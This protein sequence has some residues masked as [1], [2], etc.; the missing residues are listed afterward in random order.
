[1]KLGRILVVDD[2]T[3]IA[4]ITAVILDLAGKYEIALKT[5]LTHFVDG[6]FHHSLRIRRG[7]PG[8]SH[9]RATIFRPRTQPHLWTP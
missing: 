1:M 9:G 8:H 5:R 6:R 7:V 3:P 4:R 2:R